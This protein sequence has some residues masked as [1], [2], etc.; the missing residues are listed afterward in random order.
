MKMMYAKIIFFGLLL[1]GANFSAFA[2][3]CP[4]GMPT[5][6]NPGC[7]PPDQLN[8]SPQPPPEVRSPLW[9][10]T[11]GAIAIDETVTGGGL[12][13]VIGKKTKR[14][15]QK[16]AL[17]Q[18]RATGGGEKCTVFLTYRNQCAVI[19]SGQMKTETASAESIEKATRV[20]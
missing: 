3:G 16:A 2:Q 12:G 17:Q 20:E 8:Q 13:T 15:A 14:D 10:K 4:Y 6:G 5:A 11:W 7:I 18:C 9:A 19:V 1:P